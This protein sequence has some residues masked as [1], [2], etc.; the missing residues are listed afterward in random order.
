LD[1]RI[2]MLYGLISTTFS[3]ELSLEYLAGNKLYLKNIRIRTADIEFDPRGGKVVFGPYQ[4]TVVPVPVTGSGSGSD[5]LK[6]LI[7]NQK[8]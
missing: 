1:I 3:L 5:P 6:A 4:Q 2:L 8:R 7:I